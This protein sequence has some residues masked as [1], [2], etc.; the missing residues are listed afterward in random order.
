MNSMPADWPDYLR[1]NKSTLSTMSR[2]IKAEDR[3]LA[4]Y[5]MEDN[6]FD[7]LCNEFWMIL[8]EQILTSIWRAKV[9]TDEK[10]TKKWRADELAS[11]PFFLCLISRLENS[12]PAW[13]RE[14]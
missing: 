12:W 10:L 3:E 8:S 7:E 13:S 9:K 5:E 6:P 4:Y 1:I 14:H 2:Y 11:S